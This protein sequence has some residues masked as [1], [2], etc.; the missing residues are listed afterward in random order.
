MN[1]KIPA[2][3]HNLNQTTK[4]NKD[5]KVSVIFSSVKRRYTIANQVNMKVLTPNVLANN[6]AYSAQ[7]HPATTNVDVNRHVTAKAN[8]RMM[9]SIMNDNRLIN[10]IN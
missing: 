10:V 6:K 2:V 9:V 7:N 1:R 5:Y 3:T 8:T 4:I